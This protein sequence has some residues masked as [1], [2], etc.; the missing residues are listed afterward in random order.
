MAHTRLEYKAVVHA[1]ACAFA[2]MAMGLSAHAAPPRTATVSADGTHAVWP[3]EDGSGY[4]ISERSSHADWAA[5][6]EISIRGLVGTPV[7]SPNGKRIAFENPR[8]GYAT[9][10]P[11]RWGP[12]RAYTWGYIAVYDFAD[13]RIRYLDPSFGKDANPHWL[14]DR[15]I[16]YT[17]RIEG[18]PD[19]PMSM[20][21]EPPAVIASPD[22]QYLES[23]LG[24]PLVYQPTRSGDGESI[25]FVAREGRSLSVYFAHRSQAAQALVRYPDDDGQQL[26]QLAVS[27][28]GR[29]VAYV[30]GGFPNG[31]GEVPNPRSEAQ[32]PKRQI[33]LVSSADR[34]APQLVGAGRE[35]QFAPD[36]RSLLW[37][38]ARGIAMATLPDSGK[39][40]GLGAVQYV[41]PGPAEALR[42]S[43][44]G[45]RIAYQRSQYVE[46]YDLASRA[47]WA[48]PKP[49]EASDAD[50]AWSADGR[51]IAF[52][53]EFGHQPDNETGLNERFVAKQPWTIW[54]ADL[55]AHQ[56]RQIWHAEA[57]VGS[58]YYWLD[59][60]ATEAGSLGDQLFWSSDNRIAFVWEHDGWRHLYALSA[61]GG[62]ARLLTPGNGEVE[63][64][65]LSLDR[66]S[67][68]YSTNIGDLERRH[69]ATVSFAGTP[70]VQL[71][72][73]ATSQWAPAAVAGGSLAYIEGGWAKPPAVVWQDTDHGVI[74]AG[75]DMPPAFPAAKLVEPKAVSFH[76]SDGGTAYGQLFVPAAPNGCGVV[77]VHGGI[78][79]QML[80]GFH[81]M[82]V[83]SNLYELNQYFVSRGCTVLSVE[84]RSSIMRGYDFRNAQ[85]WGAAGASEYQDVLGGANYLKSRADLHIRNVGIYGLSWGGYLTAQALA[86]NSD[87]F[88]V[89]FDMAGVHSFPGAAFKY[90]PAAFAEHWRSPVYLAAGDDDRNVDFNQTILLIQ[91]LR[92][93]PQKVEIVEKVFPDETHA[94]Y[95]TFEHLT[96]LYW[97]GSEF[98]LQHLL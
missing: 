85:G 7:F 63:A 61:E 4:W 15:T 67:L 18:A 38:T 10:E 81:Y 27:A 84:Y 41:L 70:P 31:K 28:D 80:L 83:Y 76:G 43:P 88:K 1:A 62:E 17:R 13:G 77:F 56:A 37:L 64:A 66:R 29:W 71:T 73:G 45:S 2:L 30:R 91:A 49:A 26:S 32:P 65:T 34:S 72:R 23:L 5:P 42:F 14:D 79:R 74:V 12:T 55:T 50:P 6:H 75:P 39:T 8:G 96:D 3:K 93:N 59:P 21:V 57:G 69:I 11:N 52:R 44:D 90:S 95:L 92:S 20:P 22:R 68:I 82:D 47:T 19:A 35:P 98:M 97:E 16:G 87:V 94:L 33:W 86:R 40:D 60:D 53:R 51:R 89:G 25:A 54:V 48:I 58:A 78:V 46:I 36:G 9:Q 24:A